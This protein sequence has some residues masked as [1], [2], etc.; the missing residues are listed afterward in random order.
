MIPRPPFRD[1]AVVP[2]DQMRMR[3]DNV[4]TVKSGHAANYPFH[5][6][7]K[8]LET[9]KAAA[10]H[11]ETHAETL[12]QR[13]LQEIKNSIFGLTADQVAYH[14]GESPF[15]VRPRLTELHKRNLIKDSGTRAQN[16]SGMFAKCWVVV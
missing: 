10:D 12:R 5:P 1:T 9:S 8:D 13:V 4:K 15:S 6:G 7:Y 16:V 11:I 3:E 14:L 2:K